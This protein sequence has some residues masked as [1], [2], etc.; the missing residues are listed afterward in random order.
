MKNK[1]RFYVLAAKDEENNLIK[2]FDMHS[3]LL[4]FNK[5]IDE[6]VDGVRK[7]ID[8]RALRC[9][10]VKVVSKDLKQLVVPI[11]RMKSEDLY[12]E[13]PDKKDMSMVDERLY[14]MNAIF[15]SGIHNVAFITLDKNGP[16]YNSMAKYLSYF[17]EYKIV[18]VPVI[19]RITLEAIRNMKKVKGFGF[20]LLLNDSLMEQINQEQVD[21]KNTT[22]LQKLVPSLVKQ[23]DS[24]NCFRLSVSFDT[25]SSSRTACLNVQ[26][27]FT[28]L[29]EIDIEQDFIKDLY[30]RGAKNE[31]TEINKNSIKK[32]NYYLNHTF[33][34]TKDE[35]FSTGFIRDNGQNAISAHVNDFSSFVDEYFK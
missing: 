12:R 11:G 21:N 9:L 20:E 5:R 1:V 32:E 34:L 6:D 35:K 15:Y 17:S 14:D 13:N 10:P 3:F 2:D 29:E 28:I 7:E 31:N 22:L 30:I 19:Q 23:K 24:I 18:I 4:S 27:L 8:K 16:S 26:T 25:D 33:T